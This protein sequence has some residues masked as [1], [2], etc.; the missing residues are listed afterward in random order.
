MHHATH[1]DQ[2]RNSQRTWI[3]QEISCLGGR[4]DNTISGALKI[5]GGAPHK[6]EHLQLGKVSF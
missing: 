5:P 4:M 6:A 2:V 1:P 3:P